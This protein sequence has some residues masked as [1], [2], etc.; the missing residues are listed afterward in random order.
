MAVVT[1]SRELGS[2][3]TQIAEAVATTLG[4]HCVDK[5]VL[6]EMARQAGVS[7]EII[8]QAE[9]RLLSRPA[10]VSQEMQALFSRGQKSQ[11][12]SLNEASYIQQMTQAIRALADQGNI[13]FVGR[14]AQIILHD[15]PDILHV[16]LYAAL[17]VRAK[18]I[19]RRRGLPDL[20][21]A[22]RI[23][24]QAD[25]ERRSWFRRFF[26]GADWKNPKHYHLMIDTGRV[27]A[28][29]AANLIVQAVRTAPPGS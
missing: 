12:G 13:V 16:H 26:S 7:V 27:T 17:E 23:I 29:L 11:S 1:I 14:G 5:E 22:L 18:R 28:E 19:Q 24:R 4:T 8:V 10:L 2:R 20:E 9:E 3:G 15:R 6:A 21:P 25:D